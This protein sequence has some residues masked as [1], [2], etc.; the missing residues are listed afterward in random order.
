MVLQ[1]SSSDFAHV[2]PSPVKFSN[3]SIID[4]KK[5]L[6]TDKM[7][8]E[9]T[10]YDADM[11]LTASD[12]GELLTVTAK[13]TGKL[14]QNKKSNANSDKILANFRKV[15]CS[16]KDKEKTKGKTEVSSIFYAEERQS[17]ADNSEVSKTTD[18]QTELFHSQTEQL[19][20]RNSVGKQ[21]LLNTSKY[22]QPQHC[23]HKA[24]DTRRTYKVTFISTGK[25]KTNKETFSETFEDTESKAQKAD[26]N[27][28]IHKI[29]PEVYYGENVPFQHNTPNI[30]P[31]QWDFLHTNEKHRR[32][33]NRKTLKNPSKMNTAK[34]CRKE[35]G[36]CGKY[37]SKR[38]QTEIHQHNNKRK[39]DQKNITKIKYNKK[40]S[41]KQSG[42]TEH[43]SIHK[44]T[45]KADKKSS[46]LSPGRLKHTLAKAS[47]KTYVIPKENFT[48][49][50]PCKSEELK[51][52]DTFHAETI[53]GNKITETWQMQ[54]AL[55]TQNVIA[56]NTPQAKEQ[57]SDNGSMLKKIDSS[58]VAHKPLNF[59]NSPDNQVKHKQKFG[60]DIT[61]TTPEKNHFRHIDQG[62]QTI[63]DNEEVPHETDSL[64]S[65]LKSTVQKSENL[66]F[67]PVQCS[68]RMPLNVDSFSQE[69]L[70]NVKLPDLDNHDA[71]MNFSILKNSEICE[72]NDHRK[73]LDSGKAEQKLD[74]ISKETNKKTLTPCHGKCTG[75]PE[76][77]VRYLLLILS[78]YY[79]LLRV[80]K[81]EWKKVRL[82]MTKI[83]HFLYHI[84][85]TVSFLI[86]TNVV[87]TFQYISS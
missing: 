86:V 69:G 60:S 67:L 2:I 45:C 5:L 47:Q 20:T 63:L 83:I 16:K 14:H 31:S 4:F 3:E 68:K 74:H 82:K 73:A 75:V 50:S 42:E 52:K 55:V 64:M 53:H 58:S 12:A 15:K 57:V 34:Y 51:N 76:T 18:S 9:E 71:S 13:H 36:Q 85:V 26:S 38:S 65:K 6:F 72:G 49:F 24:K 17:R 19:P 48:Q 77:V 25:Q 22:Y 41:Y 54:V 37:I 61:E 87:V 80:M 32:K 46:H 21:I 33:I 56:M 59:S 43:D 27:S 28:S 84:S 11:E 78:Y 66:K 39:Q 1:K 40:G 7:K 81:Q 44:I 62:G 29:P 8:P 79:C 70:S 10:V 30:L 23:P 35:N